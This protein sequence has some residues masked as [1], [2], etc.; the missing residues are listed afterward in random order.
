MFRDPI[1]RKAGDLLSGVRYPSDGEGPYETA[2]DDPDQFHI[3]PLKNRLY[4]I[5]DYH[6]S[7]GPEEAMIISLSALKNPEFQIN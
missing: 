3:Y 1:G 2:W 5:K 4:H 6:T 7:G